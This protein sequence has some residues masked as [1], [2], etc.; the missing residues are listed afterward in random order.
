MS[1]HKS[2]KTRLTI[3]VVI[4][5]IVVASGAGFGLRWYQQLAVQKEESA[6]QAIVD[7]V[8]EI[9]NKAL[10]GDYEEAQ[11]ALNESLSSP[12]I[13][14][15]E[16]YALLFQQGVMYENQKEYAKAITSLQA[17]AT[18]KDTS[19]IA[20]AI[21]RVAEAKGD[22]DLAKSSY[23]KAINLTPADDPMAEGNKEFYQYRI[24]HLGEVQEDPNES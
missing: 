1:K 16:K 23:Q 14:N 3:I 2:N 20:E 21:G 6:Q 19:D 15:E 10:S 18:I 24:D 11:K 4:S 8:G 13:S 12:N 5:V 22:F 7:K 17:A 9:Q